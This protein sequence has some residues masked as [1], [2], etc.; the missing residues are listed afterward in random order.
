MSVVTLE[1]TT[2]PSRTMS[3]AAHLAAKIAETKNT[4]ETLHAGG[5]VTKDAEKQLM[6]MNK[7]LDSITRGTY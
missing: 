1:Q 6:E 3:R 5:H 7:D 2:T 4:I